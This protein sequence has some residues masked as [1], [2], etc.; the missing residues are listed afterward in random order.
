MFSIRDISVVLRL[1]NIVIHTESQHN[2]RGTGKTLI[3]DSS[4]QIAF[5]FTATDAVF[6]YVP[7]ECKIIAYYYPNVLQR[8]LSNL[9][10]KLA[11]A[12]PATALLPGIV[13]I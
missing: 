6:I 7:L 5:Y 2:G 1:D 13:T 10:S 9:L 12:E 3:R 8:S 4:Y 11:Q